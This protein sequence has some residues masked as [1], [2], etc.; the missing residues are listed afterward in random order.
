MVALMILGKIT[1][2]KAIIIFIYI[3]ATFISYIYLKD[4]ICESRLP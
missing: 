2:S 4:N 1:L 3:I